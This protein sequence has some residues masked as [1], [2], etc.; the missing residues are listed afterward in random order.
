MP[1]RAKKLSFLSRSGGQALE[2]KTAKAVKTHNQWACSSTVERRLCKAEASGSKQRKKTLVKVPTGP[3]IVGNNPD[4]IIQNN[5]R[6]SYSSIIDERCGHRK[7]PY[8]GGD[9]K[10]IIFNFHVYEAVHRLKGTQ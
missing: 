4:Q 8:P 1:S 9:A 5:S 2:N 3:F 7:I 10:I 6:N